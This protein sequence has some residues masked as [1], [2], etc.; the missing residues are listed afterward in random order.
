MPLKSFT[1]LFETINLYFDLCVIVQ[2][3][4]SMIDYNIFHLKDLV[5]TK[6]YFIPA[7][8]RVKRRF[9]A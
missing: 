6:K 1:V 2:F 7:S 4:R 9:K 5:R 3:N 8:E